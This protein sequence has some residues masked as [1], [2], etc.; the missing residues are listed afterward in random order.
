[1]ICLN[2]GIVL[3]STL[4]RPGGGGVVLPYVG[5]MGMYGPKGYR[6]LVILVISRVSIFAL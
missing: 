5:Y 4:N 6:Y 2:S 1:M 3:K